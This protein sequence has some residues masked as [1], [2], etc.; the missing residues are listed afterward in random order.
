MENTNDK[1]LTVEEVGSY[2]QIPKQTL[3]VW[4]REGKIPAIKVGKHWRFKKSS[5]DIWMQEKEKS[6]HKR[7]TVNI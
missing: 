6:N 3:Y 5:L 4:A 2:L 1:I 7:S